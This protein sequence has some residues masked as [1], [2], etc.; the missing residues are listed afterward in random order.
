MNISAVKSDLF[1]LPV[2]L[3]F[4]YCIELTELNKEQKVQECP[5]CFRDKLCQ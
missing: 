2:A 3:L 4:K 5:E 1:H